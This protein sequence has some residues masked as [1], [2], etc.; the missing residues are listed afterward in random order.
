M[1]IALPE[2][3]QQLGYIPRDLCCSLEDVMKIQGF[4]VSVMRESAESNK[5]SKTELA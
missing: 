2:V 4:M 3:T 1:I 5:Q